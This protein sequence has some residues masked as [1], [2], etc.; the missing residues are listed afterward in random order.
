M[1]KWLK[2]ILFTIASA[3]CLFL[4]FI[5]FRYVTV[6]D[7]VE[8]GGEVFVWKNEKSIRRLDSIMIQPDSVTAYIEAVMARGNVQGLGISII[9]NNQ[10]VYQRYFGS[11]NKPENRSFTPGTIWYGASLSKTILADVVL[12]LDEE[13]VLTLDT[14]LYRYLKQPLYSYKT[15]VL[16]Q[17]FGAKFIDYTTLEKDERYKKITARMCLSHTTGLPNWRWLEPGQKLAIKFEPGSRFSYSGEGMFLLQFVIEELTGK[18]FEEIALE[19]VFRPQNMSRSSYVWQR[20]YEGSYAV[21]HNHNGNYLGIPKSNV[22]NAAGSLSTTLEEYTGYFLTVL[23][24][25]EPRYQMLITPQIA[26]KSKQQ[27]GPNALVDTDENSAINLS[28][29]LGFGLYETPFGN[30]FFKEGH[31]EGWQHYAVGFPGEGTALVMMSNSDNAESIFNELIQ[32]T[33]GNTYTPWYWEGY[34]E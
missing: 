12:Q 18:D 23:Q 30:A 2:R 3:L 8:L 13:G 4:L 31:L 7:R 32:F 1:K 17:F 21:G 9:N 25:D 19:K 15:N 6:D 5:G 29:G 14:P 26:I 10:L 16:Q 20:A 24:Q 33:T 22:S 11:G 27:F 28:Y 34:G